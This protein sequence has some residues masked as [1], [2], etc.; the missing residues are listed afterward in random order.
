M[1][2]AFIFTQ[3][4]NSLGTD[5]MVRLGNAKL[6]N[7]T[8][9]V[10]TPSTA[11][12]ICDA[13]GSFH[14]A[15][16]RL[17]EIYE[18]RRPVFR[19]DNGL[20]DAVPHAQR[21][22]A[23]FAALGQVPDGTLDLVAYFGHGIPQGLESAGILMESLP[24]FAALIQRKCKRGATVVFWACLTGTPNGFA[25]RLSDMLDPAMN[26][27]VYGH[28]TAGLYSDIPSFRKFPGNHRLSTS[29]EPRLSLGFWRRERRAAAAAAGLPF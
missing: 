15:S 28:A 2:N 19:F 23:I 8:G 16:R 5:L 9:R 6:C 24:Q 18:V 29:Y 1:L 12:H 11:T 20:T 25:S 13:S 27:W 26:I 17:R 3:K 22:N 21:R 10:G 14:E 4:Y 7:A